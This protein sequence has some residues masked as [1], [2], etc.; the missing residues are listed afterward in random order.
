MRA[1]WTRE[2]LK[3]KRKVLAGFILAMVLAAPGYAFVDPETISLSA[4]SKSVRLNETTIIRINETDL[5]PQ[6]TYQWSAVRGAVVANPNPLA[7]HT[8]IY[9]ATA[10]LDP[11]ED[12]IT[13][14]IYDNTPRLLATRTAVVLV[15]KQFIVLKAGTWGVIT[16]N[17]QYYF[18]Q[19]LDLHIKTAVAIITHFIDPLY[20]GYAGPAFV[21]YT[22]ARHDSGYVEFWNNGYDFSNGAGPPAWWEFRG[23]TYGSQKTHLEAGQTLANTT[24]GFPFTAFG[25]PYNQLDTTTTTVVNESP[26]LRVWLF[27]AATG[28]TKM[29]L[30]HANGEIEQTTGL[31]SFTYFMS[32]YSATPRYVVL[33]HNPG[34]NSFYT[35]FQQFRDILNYLIAQKVTFILPTEYCRLIQDGI[36]PSNPGRTPFFMVQPTSQTVNPTQKI[37]LTATAL[38]TQPI[39]YQWKKGGTN[40]S[41]ATTDTL[42]ITAAG[43]SDEGSYLCTATNIHGSTDSNPAT[44]A[45][46]DPPTITTQPLSQ[47]LDPGVSVTFTVEATGTAPLSYEWRKDNSTIPDATDPSYTIY[48]VAESDEG[49]YACYVSN[50]AGS[51]A[52]QN[53]LSNSAFFSVNNPA[54]VIAD[55]VSAT[56][57]YG[58]SATFYVMAG[59]TPPISYQWRRNGIGIGAA[60]DTEY[61]IDNCSNAEEDNYD[62]VVTNSAGGSASAAARL[63]VNDPIIIGQP[64]DA[65]ALAMST[66]HFT[67]TA[68]GS[69]EIAYQWFKETTVLEDAGKISGATSRIL[70]IE[71]VTDSDQGVYHCAVTG[72]DP[73]IVTRDAL[74]EISDPAFTTEPLSQTVNPTDSVTFSIRAVGTPPFSYQWRDTNGI[75]I[76]GAT[77]E[78]FVI[79]S[80]AETDEGAY[81][82]LVTSHV[83]PLGFES[84]QAGLVVNDPPLIETQPESK[85]VDPT[86]LVV[87]SVVATGTD[88]LSYEWRIGGVPIP[89]ATRATYTIVSAQ[90]SDAGPYTCYVANEAGTVSGHNTTSGPAVLYLYGLPTITVPPISQTVDPNHLVTFS[91]VAASETPMS[92]QWRLND[93]NI[94]DMTES[95]LS[96]PLVQESDEGDY[97]CVVGNSAG[98][99]TNT[100]TISAP[101]TLTVNDPPVIVV[102]PESQLIAPEYEVSFSV[103]IT[104][105]PP[106]SF[107]WRKGATTIGEETAD[108]YTSSYTIAS[109]ASSDAGVYYCHVRNSAGQ[110]TSDGATLRV[111]EP[112][113]I[114]TQP[115]SQELNYGTAVEFYVQADGML[116]LY[117]EWRKNGIA[118]VD[119]GRVLGV[120]EARLSIEAAEN[121]DEGDYTCYVI[122]D[123]GGIE[124]AAATLIVHDPAITA[125]PQHQSVMGGHTAQFSIGAVGSNPVYRWYKNGLAL[126]DTGSIGGSSTAVLNVDNCQVADEGVYRC[127]VAGGPDADVT[128]Q[129]AT[130]AIDDPAVITQ[131]QSQ[132]VDPDDT[133]TFALEVDLDSSTPITFQWRKDGNDIQDASGGVTIG[134]PITYVIA[135]A[136]ETDEGSY[137]CLLRGFEDVVSNA[138]TLSVNDVPVISGVDV[139]PPDARIQLS[140]SASFTVQLSGGTEP[141]SYEWK[142]D[143]IVLTESDHVSGVSQR[144]LIVNPAQQQDEGRYTCAVYNSAG[145][146]VSS[147]VYLIVGEIRAFTQQPLTEQKK[148]IGQAVQFEVE[149]VGGRGTPHYAWTFDERQKTTQPVGDDSPLLVFTVTQAK[150]GAYRCGVTDERDTYYSNTSTLDVASPLEILQQPR[151]GL[152]AEGSLHTFAVQTSGGFL[153]LAYEWHKY[154]VPT[155]LG[156]NVTLTLDPL[157]TSDSGSYYVI[158]SDAISSVESNTAPL[159]VGTNVPAAGFVALGLLAGICTL[160]GALTLGSRGR[161]TFP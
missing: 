158:V 138:A 23:T 59:G 145:R 135:N 44:L 90:Q 64:E 13:V 51:Q 155:V 143:G 27:G 39:S 153:P 2:I 63:A 11:G 146:A 119:G 58:L 123:F 56:T 21:T 159:F 45:V 102:Q 55:P 157:Q 40:V 144:T 67:V 17:W 61:A 128:S 74:L 32:T 3:F 25:A 117:Y 132:T 79:P 34:M 139:D 26:E 49:A 82:C 52:S 70:Q 4:D 116:P 68:A 96:I 106:F 22:K 54:Y 134:L 99:K 149:T 57:D 151:G 18:Q 81:S 161:S 126:S 86:D 46:D 127:T 94:P 47:T 10:G 84:A 48:P 66:V 19:L 107:Q 154:D 62:C 73:T 71:G 8:A 6:W 12:V 137:T 156:T 20:S 36:L 87:F 72:G 129:D 60:T 80:V 78:D 152:V 120:S 109:V 141:I 108:S 130:L 112:A 160:V 89:G 103:T 122:N 124:S 111:L 104:G 93:L 65:Q 95:T 37:T 24:L 69:G 30:T 140:S 7:P 105:T 76:E 85:S 114:V 100:N 41:D 121:G 50:A 15:F 5:D 131:P 1:N 33:Q 35:N 147:E 75:D 136:A 83:R 148:Y 28:S 53:V 113:R 97:T 31:P 16:T 150:A 77:S 92:Y 88:P 115:V 38:G 118:L 43:Q 133:V 125:Q 42:I 110:V 142:K 101:A 98:D 91:V 9:T 29:V 14:A